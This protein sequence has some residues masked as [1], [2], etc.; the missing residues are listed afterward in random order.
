MAFLKLLAA[1]PLFLLSLGLGLLFVLVGLWSPLGFTCAALLATVVLR[2]LTGGGRD[3][4]YFLAFVAALVLEVALLA[5]IISNEL[6]G[7]HRIMDGYAAPVLTEAF[8]A[9]APVILY[10]AAVAASARPW[11]R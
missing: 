9:F 11:A 7:M 3:Y 4:V 5:L 2:V 6:L 10:V 1:V 8:I